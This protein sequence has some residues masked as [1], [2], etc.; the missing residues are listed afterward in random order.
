MRTLK[1]AAVCG[2]LAGCGGGVAQ[3][4]PAAGVPQTQ[5]ANAAYW[6]CVGRNWQREVS[7]PS[8]WVMPVGVAGG[9][10]EAYSDGPPREA[11]M[12][13]CMAQQGYAKK[14]HLELTTGTWEP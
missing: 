8:G 1:V 4:A 2:L 14:P 3:Y 12:R 9:I 5:S 10:A 7:Q 11:F 6:D 13:Y